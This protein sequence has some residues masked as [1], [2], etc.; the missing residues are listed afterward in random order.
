M[1]RIRHSVESKKETWLNE[2]LGEKDDMPGLFEVM[3][4]SINIMQDRITRSRMAGDPPDLMLT[5]RLA[6][7]GVLEFDRA[8]EVIAEGHACVERMQTALAYAVKSSL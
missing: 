3:A 4:G 7:I 6:H 2:L 1:K 8:D 5:P